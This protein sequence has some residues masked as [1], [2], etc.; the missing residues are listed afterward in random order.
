MFVDWRG[1]V[2]EVRDF[3]GGF[4]VDCSECW[5]MVCRKYCRC[6]ERCSRGMYLCACEML[7]VWAHGCVCVWVCRCVLFVCVFKKP[8]EWRG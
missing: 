7:L 4:V 8:R 5:L 2:V 3:V 6:C 1:V